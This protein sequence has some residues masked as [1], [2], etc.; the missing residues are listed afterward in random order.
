MLVLFKGQAFFSQ[1]RAP[2]DLGRISGNVQVISQLYNEDSIIGAALPD[3]KM[4][5]KFKLN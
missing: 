2:I 3:F 1:D 4:G 5:L